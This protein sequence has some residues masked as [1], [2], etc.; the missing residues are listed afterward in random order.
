MLNVLLINYLKKSRLVIS[1]HITAVMAFWGGVDL[2][3]DHNVRRGV[4]M[5][6]EE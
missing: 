4:Q 5:K 3:G 1:P 2:R 6:N